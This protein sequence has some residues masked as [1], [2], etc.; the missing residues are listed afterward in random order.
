[1]QFVDFPNMHAM[2]TATVD[3][4]RDQAAYCWFT[5]PG[6]TASVTWGEFYDQVRRV[7]KSLMALGVAPGD[8]VNIIS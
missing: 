4:H 8:K 7:G 3:R 5:A 2:L 6:Q 1:M